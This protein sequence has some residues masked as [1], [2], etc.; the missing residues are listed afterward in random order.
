MSIEHLIA[1]N[2]ALLAAFV[3]P[4]PA[5]LVAVCT[6][7]SS[8]R[9][10]GIAVGCGLGLVAATWTMMALLGLEAV[11]RL[12]PWAY[13]TAKIAG[14]IYLLYVAYKMW[15]GAKNDIETE[16]KPAKHAFRQG[17]MINILN[18]KS[19]L[20]AAAVLIVIFPADMTLLENAAVVLNHV[21][22]EILLYTLLAVALGTQSV[23]KRYLRAKLYLERFSAIVLGGFGLRL[24]ADR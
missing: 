5:L 17:M 14:A 20:F 2:I 15:I 6:T 7:L 9:R 4:G 8:G 21:V 24:V 1:F 19:V 16:I 11:F 23:R 18:P 10:A 22:V 13:A 12:V 3:S